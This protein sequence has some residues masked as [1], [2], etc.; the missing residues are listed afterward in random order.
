[1]SDRYSDHLTSPVFPLLNQSPLN[2]GSTTMYLSQSCNCVPSAPSQIAEVAESRLRGNGYLALRSISCTF[3][4]GALVLRGYVPTY[5]LKQV[6]QEVVS[7]IDGVRAVDN[8][9]EVAD[10][11]YGYFYG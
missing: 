1:M 4:R 7:K 10:G 2:I 6:A 5:F 9:I 3:D 11:P 8:R